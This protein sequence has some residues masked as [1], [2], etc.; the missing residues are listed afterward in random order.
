MI[1]D[2]HAHYTQAPPQLDAYRGRQLSSL[3]RPAKGK[4][5]VTD[6]QVEKSVQV[7]FKQMAAKGIDKLVFSPRASGMGHDFGSELVSRY[8]TEINNDLIARVCTMFPD[9]LIPS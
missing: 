5:N 8:W 1:I 9:R 2:V 7:N 4:I 3:N 6:E